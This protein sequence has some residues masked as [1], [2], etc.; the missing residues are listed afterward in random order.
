MSSPVRQWLSASEIAGLPGCPADSTDVARSA[1]RL[2][3]GVRTETRSGRPFKIYDRATLPAEAQ[4]ELARREAAAEAELN[5]RLG[6][7]QD[8][9]S[10][11]YRRIREEKIAASVN[12]APHAQRRAEARAAI[13]R[14]RDAFW[15]ANPDLRKRPANT[16]FVDAFNAGKIPVDTHG[17]RAKRLSVATLFRWERQALESWKELGGAYGKRAGRTKIDEHQEWVADI[18]GQM[19]ARPKIRPSRIYEILCARYGARG[20]VTERTVAAWMERWKRLN[21]G[22]WAHLCNPDAAR[23]SHKPAVGSQTKHVTRLNQL[24][25]LDSTPVDVVLS[26]G[27]RR[28][29]VAAIDIYSRR[30]CFVLARSSSSKDV[31]QVLRTAILRWGVPEAVLTDNGSDYV[32][33][34][35]CA[36]LSGLGIAHDTTLPYC[37]DLK[38]AV[39]R[40]FRTMQHDLVELLPGFCGHSVAQAQDIRSQKTFSKRLGESDQEVFDADL[41]ADEF[42]DFLNRWCVAYEARPHSGIDGHTP[43]QMVESWPGEVRRIQN[44]R[45]LDILL[46]PLVKPRCIS[47]KG[48]HID[49]ATFASEHGEHGS[50]L[51]RWVNVRRD[52][53][54]VGRVWCFDDDGRYLFTAI[55]PERTGVSRE[56]LAAKAMADYKEKL[57]ENRAMMRE[58]KRQANTSHIAEEILAERLLQA[59]VGVVVPLRPPVE[60]TVEHTTPAL[61][62]AEAAAEAT[63]KAPSAS[64]CDL[65]PVRDHARAIEDERARE[66]QQAIDRWI[67]LAATPREERSEREQRWFMRMGAQD[68][69]IRD[70]VTR[71]RPDLRPL[72]ALAEVGLA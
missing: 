72:L 66:N 39:E 9:T 41:S 44:E 8:A 57:T 18:L 51:G 15:A 26:D 7:A 20:Q 71:N 67:G 59:G 54:D 30:L 42:V 38:G 64:V 33:H 68:P 69:V 48:L 4:A 43:R 27:N 70:H 40:A 65:A 12:L 28:T 29:I 50:M 2:S 5:A 58:F 6:I 35:T 10:E 34:Q 47:K 11:H 46:Q 53:S 55:C 19:A 24:W 61:E 32:S 36:L 45:A 13:L 14:A 17:I 31:G 21:P 3:W 22:L 60:A 49:N 62:G 52:P 1:A 23:G 63:S 56:E 37:G 25:L 16:A